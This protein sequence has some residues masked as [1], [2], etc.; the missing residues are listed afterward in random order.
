M[1]TLKITMILGRMKNI[2]NYTLIFKSYLK[3]K[4][5]NKLNN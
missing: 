4:Q 5:I 1:R 3:T 2:N